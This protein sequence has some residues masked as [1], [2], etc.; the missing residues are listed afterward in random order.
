MTDP[1]TAQAEEALALQLRSRAPFLL[2]W[3]EVI[4]TAVENQFNGRKS[5]VN[6]PFWCMAAITRLK[7]EASFVRK[8]LYRKK[9]ADPLVEITDQVGIRFVTLLQEDADE[10]VEFI[11]SSDL[12]KADHSRD[13]RRDIH[14][15]PSHFEY[16]A[17]HILLRPTL[18]TTLK[19]GEVPVGLCCEVQVRTLLQHAHGEL[20]H[21]TTYKGALSDN[22]EVVRKV[23]RS[24]A[25][26]EGADEIFGV[27]SMRM[28]GL[29]TERRRIEELSRRFFERELQEGDR[30]EGPYS[31]YIS[32]ALLAN[33]PTA[34]TA[35]AIASYFET[36][37]GLFE[38]IR[39]KAEGSR[40]FRIAPVFIAIY[41]ASSERSYL[42]K[43][44]PLTQPELDSVLRVAGI[45][46]SS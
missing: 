23:A 37:S 34:V 43:V 42:D 6:T 29:H 9:Y 31:D 28:S 20:T 18:K 41:L 12:W 40:L 45:S 17:N 32:D 26:I 15:N 14:E 27:V 8:A 22:V 1:T 4:R 44:W 46:G 19:A 16:F 25:L 2:E 24:A 10:V 38:N 7:D 33:L 3:L 13:F 11:M 36:N 5:A 39:D 30:E 21:D 35:D